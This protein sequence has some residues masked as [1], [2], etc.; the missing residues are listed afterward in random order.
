VIWPRRRRGF[1]R[2]AAASNIASPSDVE[3]LELVSR[4]SRVASAIASLAEET[5][6]HLAM[7]AQVSQARA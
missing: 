1:H 6:L 5:V 3:A 2:G 4:M 7:S